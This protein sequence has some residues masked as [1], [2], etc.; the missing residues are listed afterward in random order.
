MTR[1]DR[2]ALYGRVCL[3]VVSLAMIGGIIAEPLIRMVWP[4]S[5]TIAQ[6]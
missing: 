2:V 1:K 6:R 5:L 3:V 4:P